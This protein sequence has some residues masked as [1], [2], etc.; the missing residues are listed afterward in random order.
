[1]IFAG[2]F[3]LLARSF[4]GLEMQLQILMQT[5]QNERRLCQRDIPCKQAKQAN[6]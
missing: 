4:V 1:M 2:I 5:E 3:T 6:N